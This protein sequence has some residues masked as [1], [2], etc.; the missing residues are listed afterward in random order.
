VQVFENLFNHLI[1]LDACDH[2]HCDIASG[3]DQRISS[4]DFLYQ[5]RLVS[6]DFTFVPADGNQG[7]I[8]NPIRK[9]NVSVVDH[10]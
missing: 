3:T 4:I 1:I 10:L 5:A 8:H 7:F 9:Y 2:M 6:I